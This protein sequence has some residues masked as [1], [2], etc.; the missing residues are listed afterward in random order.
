MPFLIYNVERKEKERIYSFSK[1]T[2]S[3]PKVMKQYVAGLT[4]KETDNVVTWHLN[5]S[6][7]LMR[8]G[9]DASLNSIV[10]DLKPS[11][12][13]SISLY[14][15]AGVWGY[16][17]YGWTPLLVI[18]ETFFVD[19]KVLNPSNFKQKFNLSLNLG[20]NKVHEFLYLRFDQNGGN[21]NW[22]RSGWV[23]ASLLWPDSMRYFMEIIKNNLDKGDSFELS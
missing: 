8:L 5:E 1:R 3:L 2:S 9:L 20:G 11:Q 14:R 17:G 22:G 13:E 7:L 6:D 19:H 21:A 10:V 12:T 23:N 15:L 16:S 4:S 18:L